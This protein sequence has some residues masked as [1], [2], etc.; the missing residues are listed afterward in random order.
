MTCVDLSNGC[1]LVWLNDGEGVDV[2]KR[3][4]LEV[5]EQSTS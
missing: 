5:G 3:N 2:I 4:E 1:M